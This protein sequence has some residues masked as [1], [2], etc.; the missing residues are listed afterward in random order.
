M[1]QGGYRTNNLVGIEEDLANL[2]RETAE[3]R[4]AV[5]NLTGP[6]INLT[7]QV[8]EYANHMVTMYSSMV[9]MKNKI[10]QILG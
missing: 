1:R 6:N 8:A 7:K 5:T 4:S 3:E 10:S 2:A 9:T